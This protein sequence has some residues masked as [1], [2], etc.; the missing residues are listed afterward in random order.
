MTECF[1]K[2]EESNKELLE[3]NRVEHSRLGELSSFH[4]MESF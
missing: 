1:Q 3:E 2:L 4:G